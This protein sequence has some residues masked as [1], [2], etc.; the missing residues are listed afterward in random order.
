MI[1][2]TAENGMKTKI[3]RIRLAIALP[4]VVCTPVGA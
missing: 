3:P 1:A 2:A 4:L